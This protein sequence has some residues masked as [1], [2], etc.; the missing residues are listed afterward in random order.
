MVIAECGRELLGEVS[1]DKKRFDLIKQRFDA[2]MVQTFVSFYNCPVKANDR[3]IDKPLDEPDQRCDPEIGNRWRNG[4][5]M[6]KRMVS[7]LLCAVMTASLLAGCGDSGSDA[8]TGSGDAAGGSADAAEATETAANTNAGSDADKESD[9]AADGEIVEII[10]QYPAT[11]DTTQEGFINVENALNEMMER[12]IGVHVTF[13]PVELLNAQSDAILAASSGEKLDIM[14]TAFTSM[15]NVV[16]KG[17]II[18]LDDLLKEYG[19]DI[20]ANS[21]TLDNCGYQGQTYGVTTGDVMGNSYSYLIKKSYWD[22]YNLEE[23]T[24]WTDDKIYTLD[25]IEEIFEIVKEGE[26]DKFY[27][28]VPWPDPEPLNRGY[29]EYDEIGGSLACGVLMLNRDFTDTT[30]YNL[31]ETE[32][33]AEYCKMR[34]DWAQKGYLAPD[35]AVTT[36]SVDVLVAQD[37]YLGCFS[38]GGPVSINSSSWDQEVVPLDTVPF[39]QPFN[40]GAVIQW[41]IPITCERPDKAMQALN[42]IYQNPDAAALIQFGIEG[43]DYEVVAEEG[44]LKQIQ[45]TVENAADRPYNMGYGIWGD[46][47]SWPAVAPQDIHRSEI[48]RSID[49]ECPDSRKSPAFGYSFVQEPVASEVAAVNTVIEQYARSLNCGALDPEKALPE[50]IDALKAAGMDKII[51]EQQSQLDAWL[52]GKAE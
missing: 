32:E 6:K 12:D 38:W 31:F 52:A 3:Q 47:L 43:V 18:P 29:I 41:S 19:Q 39:Y 14:L 1:G 17:L 22:K 37:N 4:G 26:G 15:G 11:M 25:E 13:E 36:E 27:C 24:G 28:D 49:Q 42:Y 20:I 10:W 9:T 8:Q 7:A 16:N 34:Y 50:F 45:Y 2:G 51:E 21:H 23:L 33:Y 35:A 5:E 30:V 40:G 48:R 44:D 46:S